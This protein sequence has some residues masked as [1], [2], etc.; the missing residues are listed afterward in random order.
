MYESCPES[1]FTAVRIVPRTSDSRLRRNE[2]SPCGSAVV[3]YCGKLSHRTFDVSLQAGTSLPC[4]QQPIQTD[5]ALV[6]EFDRR[7]CRLKRS[8]RWPARRG[9]HCGWRMSKRASGMGC[10]WSQGFNGRTGHFVLIERTVRLSYRSS[11]SSGLET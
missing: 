7:R 3:S 9:N 4:G 8:T 6:V 5:S 2:V 1:S 10:L 11:C